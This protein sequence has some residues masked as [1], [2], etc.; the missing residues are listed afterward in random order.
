MDKNKFAL[1]ING[2][3]TEKTGQRNTAY[4][5]WH[6]SLGSDYYAVDI[7]YVEFRK[8]RGIV[9]FLS[10]S[11]ECVDEKHIINSKKFI[12]ERAKLECKILLKLSQ[13]F[14]VPSYYVIHTA[15]LAIFHVHKIGDKLDVFKKMNQKEYS[16]FIK[17]L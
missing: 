14:N 13:E 5:L 10:V 17:N 16:N 1:R 3:K 9:A 11:G 6:R 7:D 8:D 15:D 12:W 2:T 4:S